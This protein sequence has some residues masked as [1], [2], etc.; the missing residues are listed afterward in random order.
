MTNS[1][2]NISSVRQSVKVSQEFIDKDSKKANIQRKKEKKR[3][4]KN[5]KEFN[6]LY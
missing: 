4:N 2:T 3:Q 6:M 5:I 1:K